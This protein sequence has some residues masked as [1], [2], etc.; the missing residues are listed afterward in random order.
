MSKRNNITRITC[1]LIMLVCISWC[2][3]ASAKKL[4]LSDNR[5][6][7]EI[8]VGALGSISGWTV[9]ILLPNI[10]SIYYPHSLWH[11]AKTYRLTLTV[12]SALTTSTSVYLVGT[13][14]QQT[15]SFLTTL[16]CSTITTWLTTSVLEPTK[17]T[18]LNDSW[19]VHAGSIAGAVIG[20]NL[21]RQSK[22]EK[23]KIKPAPPI[24]FQLL[25]VSFQT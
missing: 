1:G 11:R 9:G 23:T 2:K 14:D 7:S 3:T 18:K 22:K 15:G 13:S 21:R 4:N 24:R 16:A 17:L 12:F 5:I 19:L 20:F 10:A 6:I 25:K 8:G